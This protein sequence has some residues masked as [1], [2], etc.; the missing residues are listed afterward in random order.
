MDAQLAATDK[1]SAAAIALQKEIFDKQQANDT[2]FRDAALKGMA[3]GQRLAGNNRQLVFGDNGKL[4]LNAP[5][6]MLGSYGGSMPQT[7]AGPMTPKPMPVNVNADQT[8][9]SF[10]GDKSGMSNRQDTGMSNPGPMDPQLANGAQWVTVMNGM[11]QTKRVPSDQIP[12][13][14]ALVGGGVGVGGGR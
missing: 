14:W 13:G 5:N 1:S 8:L 4:S 6:R 3:E 12:Q 10:G 2:P 9:G 11:G 7:T